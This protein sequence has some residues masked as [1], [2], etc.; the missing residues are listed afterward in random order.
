LPRLSIP[1][2]RPHRRTVALVAVLAAGIV[3]YAAR[4]SRAERPALD[5][6]VCP[7][8]ALG[9]CNVQA[10]LTGNVIELRPGP[11]RPET[12]FSIGEPGDVALLGDW[13]CR[14]EYT[15]AIYRPS[16]GQVFVFDGWANPDRALTSSSAAAAIPNGRPVVVRSVGGC[17]HIDVR[18][19]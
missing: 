1:F 6:P 7:A 17:D 16:T 9:G 14:G 15:P 19:N 10:T 3:V 5:R 13:H 2:P 11:G 18:P 12:R 4:P 8:T